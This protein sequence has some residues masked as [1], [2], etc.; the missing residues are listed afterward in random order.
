MCKSWATENEWV[1]WLKRSLNKERQ[2]GLRRRGCGLASLD[3]TLERKVY[4]VKI[5][6]SHPSWWSVDTTE[7]GQKGLFS[8]S[9]RL[10][11]CWFNG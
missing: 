9:Y 1:S 11:M 3:G 8:M 6:V 7:P 10:P 5:F 4:D 2:E